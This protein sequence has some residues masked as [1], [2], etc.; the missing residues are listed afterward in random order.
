MEIDDIASNEINL[1]YTAKNIAPYLHVTVPEVPLIW[2]QM[3]RSLA[4]NTVIFPSIFES[5]EKLHSAYLFLFDRKR[6]KE[7]KESVEQ[8]KQED[9]SIEQSCR[10]AEVELEEKLRASGI[11]TQQE[12]DAYIVARYAGLTMENVVSAG[13]HLDTSKGIVKIIKRLHGIPDGIPEEISITSEL[14]EYYL[15]GCIKSG[16][17]CL[18]E[19]YWMNIRGVKKPEIVN[20]DFEVKAAEWLKE[21]VYSKTRDDRECKLLEKVV[22]KREDDGRFNLRWFYERSE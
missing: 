18:E 22:V 20:P 17:V 9:D 5:I 13:D 10:Q 12:K 1:A 11:T 3:T 15:I 16:I 4:I 21:E 14:F 8:R 19:G 7:K 6:Y 2:K